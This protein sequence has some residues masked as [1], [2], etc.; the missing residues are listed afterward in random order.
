MT[1]S[2]FATQGLNSAIIMNYQAINGNT[3]TLEQAYQLI[4]WY[5]EGK[6]NR[7]DY[8][9]AAVLYVRKFGEMEFDAIMYTIRQ[10][11][12]NRFRAEHGGKPY[13]Y[14]TGT[15]NGINLHW[16]K[17][18]PDNI[19]L[20]GNKNNEEYNTNNMTD[21]G[22]NGGFFDFNS[23]ELLSIAVNDGEVTG[24]NGF[25]V[26]NGPRYENGVPRYFDRG[27][28]VWDKV[29]SEFSVQTV[30]NKN[31]ILCITDKYWAQGGISMSLDNDGG[32]YYQ[33]DSEE[34]M[35][36]M[37][38]DGNNIFPERTGMVYDYNQQNNEYKN[39]WLIATNTPCSASNFRIAVKELGM[40]EQENF[41][42]G[43]FLDGSNSSKLR[44]KDSNGN[45]VKMRSFDED[46]NVPQ[47]VALNLKV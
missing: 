6:H 1:S 24:K 4:S 36:I 12:E 13:V 5:L 16:I 32:W 43:I 21:Y 8:Y 28:L 19:V 47:I 41:R 20:K 26:A 33:A 9:I 42:D 10:H 18:F 39:L 44:C 45:D 37:G 46:R 29:K 14:G 23:R 35:P 3:A 31:N 40:G 27:T 25:G 22:I 38:A 7:K 34:E 17:T 11:N 30:K 15:Y 2:Y